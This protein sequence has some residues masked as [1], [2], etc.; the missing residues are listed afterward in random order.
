MT[1]DELIN[2]LGLTPHP[3][4]GHFAEIFREGDG[5]TRGAV[6]SIYYLLKRGEVS[7]WHRVMDATELWHWHGGAPLALD[8]SADGEATTRHVLGLDLAAGQRPQAI[9]PEGAWQ[10]AES[11]G[12]WTLVG[13][14]VAPGFDYAG[15]ELAPAGWRPGAP[16]PTTDR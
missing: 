16:L 1:A 8:I 9:V 7:T 4:G 3:E 2:I 10:S 13:C 11:L 14:A 15:F 6:T 12:A 5:S